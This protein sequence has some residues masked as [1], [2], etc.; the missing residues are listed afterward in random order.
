MKNLTVYCDGGARGNP[1]PAAIGFVITDDKQ[2]NLVKHGQL[3]GKATNNIAEYKSII[4]ALE[5]INKNIDSKDIHVQVFMDSLLIVNQL[6][7]L[8]KVKNKNL[9]KL[10]LKAKRLENKFTKINYNHIARNKN[11]LADQLLNIALDQNA[12]FTHYQ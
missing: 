4:G 6:K 2:K 10:F 7:G 12:S 5:W 8:Y 1:G 9:L 3:I 11:K